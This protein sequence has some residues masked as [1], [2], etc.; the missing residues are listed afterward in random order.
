MQEFNIYLSFYS[1]FY[2]LVICLEVFIPENKL[3]IKIIL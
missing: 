1:Y 3:G 2:F